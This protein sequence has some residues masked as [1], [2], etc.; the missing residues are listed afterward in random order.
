MKSAQLV[1]QNSSRI[2]STFRFTCFICKTNL[3]HDDF[4]HSDLA[5]RRT[6]WT[7]GVPT[8]S[9]AVLIES[10]ASEM[11]LPEQASFFIFLF[12]FFFALMLSAFRY[13]AFVASETDLHEEETAALMPPGTLLHGLCAN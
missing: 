4:M 13:T 10:T 1:R 11:D 7:L 6:P 9:T 2:F 3:L 8:S 12:L 5:M